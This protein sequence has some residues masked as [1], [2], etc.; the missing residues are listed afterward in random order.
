M[1]PLSKFDLLIW[2]DDLL[3]K[4]EHLSPKNDNYG[5]EKNDNDGKRVYDTECNKLIVKY[6]AKKAEFVFQDN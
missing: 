5:T 1:A 2:S 3:I 6:S 4:C